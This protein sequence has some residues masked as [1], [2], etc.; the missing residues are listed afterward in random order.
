[1]SPHAMGAT[2]ETFLNMLNSA[3]YKTNAQEFS[4]SR[5]KGWSGWEHFVQELGKSL[6]QKDASILKVI[7][8]GC[9]NG[10]F[11]SYLADML[12]IP[13]KIVGIDSN[14][15][16]L[17]E[18][19][20]A[21]ED[22]ASIVSSTYL[23]ADILQLSQAS[24]ATSGKREQDKS[25]EKMQCPIVDVS[26][27]SMRADQVERGADFLELKNTFDCSVSFGM[28]HHVYS[29]ALRLQVLN[30]IVSALSPGGMAC[31]SFWQ[32]LKTAKYQAQARENLLAM[33]R[34]Y[35]NISYDELESGDVFLGWN[36]KKDSFRYVHSFTED[37]ISQ[38][39]NSLCRKQEGL[40]LREIYTPKRGNDVL[41][42]YAILEKEFSLQ[43]RTM[44]ED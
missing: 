8:W 37:E 21:A 44:M 32:P 5:T 25:T 24:K 22:A 13:F 20:L 27:G 3:F 40:I 43:N 6:Q 7:D 1:M 42:T 14:P 26:L 16:L 12:S 28:L 2:M 41:N 15:M 38:L 17:R 4:Q 9:G 31:I 18:A 10:R 11:A 39:L 29:S 33:K 35:P 23:T 36:R 34:L 19:S 30:L